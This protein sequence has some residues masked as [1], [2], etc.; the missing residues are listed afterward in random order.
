MAVLFA[1]MKLVFEGAAVHFVVISSSSD[2]AR[3][4][5]DLL[6]ISYKISLCAE[7]P[8]ESLAK[9][10]STISSMAKEY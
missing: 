2:P 9:F 3:F 4:F 8:R 7:M 10:P 1:S 5:N 6:I